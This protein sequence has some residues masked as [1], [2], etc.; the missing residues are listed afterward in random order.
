[1]KKI[2]LLLIF[3]LIL[4]V[5]S[6]AKP[7]ENWITLPNASE[8]AVETNSIRY[9]SVTNTADAWV[10]CSMDAGIR[11]ILLR[12]RIYFKTKT[13][14]HITWIKII[15]GQINQIEDQ[16]NSF[17]DHNTLIA[18]LWIEDDIANIVAK[19][20]GLSPIYSFNKKENRI[21]KIYTSPS[22]RDYFIDQDSMEFDFTNDIAYVWCASRSQDNV[23]MK[24]SLYQC[25]LRNKN[26]FWSAPYPKSKS[27]ASFHK[28]SSNLNKAPI[29]KA[30]FNYVEN[31]Y[32]KQIKQQ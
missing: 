14:S 28:E 10:K 27:I 9:D 16:T 21:K 5:T 8:W 19:K 32:K 13:Y 18:P 3:C 24:F 25:D 29:Y 22:G 12:E 23:S 26:V 17:Y 30:I 7:V 31:E 20:Y 15:N 6:F 1:M 4:T 2:I 11:T